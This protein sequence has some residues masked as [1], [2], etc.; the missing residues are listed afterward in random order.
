MNETA[1]SWEAPQYDE[2]P[3]GADW[4]WIAGIL[5]VAGIVLSI[6]ARNYLLAVLLALGIVLIFYY[7]SRTPHVVTIKLT[8]KGLV[9]DGMLYRYKNIISFWVYETP[10]QSHRMILHVDRQY[11]PYFTIPVPK[12][13]DHDELRMFMKRYTA[14]VEKREPTLDAIMRHVGL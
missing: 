11:L 14:E 9:I 6:I 13:V 1:F 8:Q 7:A 12:N 2:R 3:K 10:E 5:A 4:Y